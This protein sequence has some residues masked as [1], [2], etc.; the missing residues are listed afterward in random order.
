[1]IQRVCEIARHACSLTAVLPG[2]SIEVVLL[3]LVGMHLPL[4][5]VLVL[6]DQ[7]FTITSL[8][9]RVSVLHLDILSGDRRNLVYLLLQTLHAQLVGSIIDRL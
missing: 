5:E 1:M 4:Y 3:L 8:I 7:I 6:R 2:Q 9:T